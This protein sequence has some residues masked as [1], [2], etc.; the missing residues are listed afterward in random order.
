[1]GKGL[2][3][4][5]KIGAIDE[6][7]RRMLNIYRVMEAGTNIGGAVKSLPE[8]TQGNGELCT[9]SCISQ[10]WAVGCVLEAMLWE[11]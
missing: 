3:C 11:Q 5:K 6:Y 7:E 2:L 9:D 10:A 1:M 4:L 8:L